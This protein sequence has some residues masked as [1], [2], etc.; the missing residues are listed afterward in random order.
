MDSLSAGLPGKGMAK[1]SKLDFV[2]KFFGRKWRITTT[3]RMPKNEYG[4]QFDGDC[5]QEKRRIRILGSLSGPDFANTA[6]HESL[7]AAFDH[8]A[9]SCVDEFSSDFIA[10]LYRPDVLARCG[11]QR[12]TPEG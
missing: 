5:S 12:I 10:V 1:K 3:N 2:A 7:H 8:L 4:V 6:L 11:L 9:E